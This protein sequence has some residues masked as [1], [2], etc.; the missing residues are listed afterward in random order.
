MLITAIGTIISVTCVWITV[1]IETLAG[2]DVTGGL[3][4]PSIQHHMDQWS[5]SS[6]N[7]LILTH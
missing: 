6:L 4:D 7:P 1:M 5:T 3:K 2:G